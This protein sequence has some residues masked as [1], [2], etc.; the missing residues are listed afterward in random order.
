MRTKGLR[1]ALCR[2]TNSSSGYIH[3]NRRIEFSSKWICV[4]GLRAF[5]RNPGTAKH[6]FMFNLGIA[7]ILIA[8]LGIPFFL[9]QYV[10]Q[11]SKRLCQI[12]SMVDVLACTSSIISFTVISAERFVA[13]NYPLRYPTIISRKRCLFVLSLVWIYSIAF[14]LASWIPV[15]EFH[16]N[17]CV[18]FTD[19]YIIFTTFASFVLPLFTMLVTYGYIYK[20]AKYQSDQINSSLPRGT[21]RVK[22]EFKAA[23]TLTLIIGAF[24]VCWLPFF[25][26]IWVYSV[27]N[28]G[29][30]SNILNYVIHVVRYLNGLANPFIYV[31]INREFRR[32]ALKLLKRALPR[33]ERYSNDTTNDLTQSTDFV[34]R[35]VSAV[36]TG[37]TASA[38]AYCNGTGQG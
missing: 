1:V 28:A 8:V 27:Y 30:P 19:I 24:V 18:F 5:K 22:R 4:P 32:S 25:V 13:V 21:N 7:D 15:G 17:H 33:R 35:K 23:K 29:V 11:K 3:P 14:S 38:A 26:Y 16:M 9:T 6:Y 10:N 20:V 36:S 12:G 2:T 37:G 34:L 31:R